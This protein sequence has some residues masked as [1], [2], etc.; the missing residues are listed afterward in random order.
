MGMLELFL[1]VVMVVT[2]IKIADADGQS[3]ILWGSAA[4]VISVL[5]FMFIPFLFIRVLIAAV[6]TFAAMTAYKM[7]KK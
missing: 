6:L 3:A 1:A 5:C 2:M 7:V 4:F